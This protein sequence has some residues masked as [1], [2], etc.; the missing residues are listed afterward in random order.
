MQ[1]KETVC[2][3]KEMLVPRNANEQIVAAR[4]AV[5]ES[6]RHNVE[7]KQPGTKEEALC[8]HGKLKNRGA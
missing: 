4:T 2:S 7:Q 1:W 5:G 3:Y 8:N 6:Q